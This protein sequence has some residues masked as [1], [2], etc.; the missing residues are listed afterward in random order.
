MVDDF[1][2][3]KRIDSKI[4]WNN[5][6]AFSDWLAEQINRLGEAIGIDFDDTSIQREHRTGSLSADITCLEADGETRVVIENQF[7]K[8]NHDH[9]GKVIAYAAGLDGAKIIWI[10]QQFRDEHLAALDWLNEKTE[11]STSFLGVELECWRIDD[12]K[13]APNFNL[14]AKPNYWSRDLAR[15]VRER[16]LTKAQLLNKDFWAVARIHFQKIETRIQLPDEGKQGP[17]L[18]R[19]VSGNTYFVVSLSTPSELQI[20]LHFQD[21]DAEDCFE[22][23]DKYIKMNKA[24]V[25]SKLPSKLIWK[26]RDG[27]NRLIVDCL[28]LRFNLTNRAEWENAIAWFLEGLEGLDVALAPLV[29][30]FKQQKTDPEESQHLE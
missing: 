29:H 30:E 9:L 23:I 4:M 1:G 28:S 2:N 25:E 27:T 13:P 10:A 15:S 12:S 21:D 18:R 26:R 16:P 5:E 22:Y 8:T 19:G 7:G 6:T 20:N 11:N 14:I 3:L 17:W 24:E